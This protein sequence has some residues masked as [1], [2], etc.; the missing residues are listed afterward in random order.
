MKAIPP[1]YVGTYK[2]ETGGLIRE[3]R[4]IG[5]RNLAIHTILR[6]SNGRRLA[7]DLTCR[8]QSGL[9][10]GRRSFGYES[11]STNVRRYV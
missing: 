6:I 7:D 4:L 5:I 3:A 1:M 2:M 9:R 10:E 11:Y 8:N